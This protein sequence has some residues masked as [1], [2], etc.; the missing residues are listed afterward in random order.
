MFGHALI[1]G[2]GKLNGL[3]SRLDVRNTALIVY[4]LQKILCPGKISFIRVVVEHILK[5]CHDEQDGSLQWVDRF[6]QSG[7]GHCVLTRLDRRVV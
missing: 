3:A 7:A 4:Q 2:N 1:E 5:P 6:I